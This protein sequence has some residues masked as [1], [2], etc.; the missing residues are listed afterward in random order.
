MDVGSLQFSDSDRGA[1]PWWS[2][3]EEVS[4]RIYLP[5]DSET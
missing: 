5:V 3:E 2:A 4:G 1:E